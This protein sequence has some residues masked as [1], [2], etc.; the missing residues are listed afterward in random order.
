MKSDSEVER[1]VR[2]QLERDP[3]I[4]A[5]DIA[6]SVNN[7]VVTLVGFTHSYDIEVRLPATEQYRDR[8]IAKDAVAALKSE[9]PISPDRINVIVKDG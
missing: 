6:I 8:D 3:D 4:D 9:L 5:D 7:G 2:E 1:D